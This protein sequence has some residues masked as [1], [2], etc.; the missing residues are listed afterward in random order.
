MHQEVRQNW[1]WYVFYGSNVYMAVQQRWIALTPV[2]SLAVEEQFYLAWFFT[3]MLANR[4]KL[5]V[6]LLAFSLVAPLVRYAY[7]SHGNFFGTY[8]LWAQCDAL[9]VGAFLF[10]LELGSRKLPVNAAFAALLFLGVAVANSLRS[11]MDPLI[12]SIGQTAF[13]VVAAYVVWTSRMGFDGIV[14]EFL[15]HRYVVHL[16]KVSYG[17]YL[18]HMLTLDTAS[19]LAHSDVPGVWRLFALGTAVGFA[20]HCAITIALAILSFRYFESPIRYSIDR[21][22]AALQ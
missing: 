7:L 20:V 12:G 8:T 3:L 10:A 2:W 19:L 11:S 14:G 15:A 22:K 6:M 18:Y 13:I 9:A 16:G 17:V 4:S 5:T 1:P 21:R